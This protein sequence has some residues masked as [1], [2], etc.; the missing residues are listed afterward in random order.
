MTSCSDDLEKKINASQ[1]LISLPLCISTGRHVSTK[2]IRADFTDNA[3]DSHENSIG[4]G[5]GLAVQL[6][7]PLSC[8]FLAIAFILLCICV[9]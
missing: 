2:A 3:D 5:D 4:D 1:N 7:A 9:S 6:L 8:Q